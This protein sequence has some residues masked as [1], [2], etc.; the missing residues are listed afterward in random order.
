MFG[1]GQSFLDTVGA[2]P[3]PFGV[4]LPSKIGVFTRRDEKSSIERW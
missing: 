3:Q 1:A 4:L 2:D